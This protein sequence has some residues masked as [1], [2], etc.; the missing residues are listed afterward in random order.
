[1]YRHIIE[2]SIED[3]ALGNSIVGVA[4]LIRPEIPLFII[5]IK[6]RE[7]ESKNLLGDLAKIE[8]RS[9]SVRIILQDEIDLGDALKSLWSAYGR[10]RVEQAGRMEIVVRGVEP[11]SLKRLK[12]REE[13]IS[14]SERVNELVNKIIP[15]GFRIRRSTKEKDSLT[16]I[17]A[18]D[19]IEE[20]WKRVA[21][22]L[23]VDE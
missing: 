12:I 22:D 14:I 7:R 10:D 5:K 3:L 9:G 8:P 17:A 13:R 1:M 16:V 20:G 11:E 4:V 19:P 2:R 18:E 6:Y 23:V 21:S 15:E